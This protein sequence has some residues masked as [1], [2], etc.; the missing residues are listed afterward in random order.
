MKR[1][2]SNLWKD[3]CGALLAT[4]WVVMATI[5]VLGVIPGLIA[6]RQGTVS[7]L[8]DFSNATMSLDQSYEFNGQEIHCSDGI[9]VVDGNAR[10]GMGNGS[11]TE[12]IGGKAQKTMTAGGLEG[13]VAAANGLHGSALER[14]GSM[15]MTAG[16][17]FLQGNHT[18]DGNDFHSSTKHL[19]NGSVQPDGPSAAPAD[20]CD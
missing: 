15:A 14:R 3:D 2:F 7:E 16:S 12:I 11:I 19:N 20:P 5:I 1:S 8:V 17:S 10:R 13:N 18:A 6:I 9:Q 4:E